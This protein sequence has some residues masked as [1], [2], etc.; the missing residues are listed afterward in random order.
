M[1][2]WHT[3]Y[4]LCFTPPQPGP[5]GSG[6]PPSKSPEEPRPLTIHGPRSF[7]GPPG[8]DPAGS[9]PTSPQ[10]R[11]PE[12]PL[13]PLPPTKAAEPPS[14]RSA[15]PAPTSVDPTQPPGYV[16]NE[17]A[18]VPA[19]GVP[20]NAP[21]VPSPDPWAHL[22]DLLGI[23]GPGPHA[24]DPIT[25]GPSRRPTRGEQKL[26]NAA[27]DRDGC[28][29]CGTRYPGTQSGSW[30]GDHQDPVAIAR[31]HAPKLYYPQ[32]RSVAM[33]KVVMSPQPREG[34]TTHED[35]RHVWRSDHRRRAKSSR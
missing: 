8:L 19:E 29:R 26:I 11:E 28:H 10:G 35:H 23:F 17:K 5:K 30:I 20:T 32:A 15:K 2:V 24:G 25:A 18:K 4:D 16:F 13:P 21:G 3:L 1:R 33:R 6:P 31:P 27:G 22:P 7:S 34:V 14:Q 9:A 12:A